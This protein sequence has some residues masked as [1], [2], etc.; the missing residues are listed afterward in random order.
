MST[1]ED[2]AIMNQKR[3]IDHVAQKEG[4]I[5]SGYVDFSTKIELECYNGHRWMVTPNHVTNGNS[6]CPKCPRKVSI[7]SKENFLRVVA[8]RKGII[9][10]NYINNNTHIALRCHLGHE[11]MATP[12][13]IAGVM[14]SWCPA[15]SGNCPKE[16]ANEFY[17]IVSE[18]GGIALGEYIDT[19]TKVVIKCSNNHEWSCS[20]HSIISC[21]TW[22]IKCSNLCPEQAKDKFILTVTNKGGIILGQ[23]VNSYT[24]VRIR[25]RYDH[26]WDCVPGNI[27]AGDWCAGCAG[28][29]PEANKRLIAIVTERKGVI[30]GKYINSTSKIPFQCQ[31]G[32]I[33]NTAPNNIVNSKSWCPICNESHGE[34]AVRLI[35]EKYNIKFEPQYGH[36]SQPGRRYDFYFV[37]NDVKFYLEYDGEQHFRHVELFCKTTE[38]YES[39]RNVDIIKTHAVINSDANII[40]L[41]YTL[42]NEELESHILAAINRNDKLYI[43]NPKMYEWIISGINPAPIPI[44]LN[45]RMPATAIMPPIH[46][47]LNIIK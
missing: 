45:I 16:A 28:I 22:C 42:T 2:K 18:R 20:P 33:W 35:L 37:Y 5:L 46:M 3:F 7:Q 14:N 24:R 1:R 8:E 44:T 11:W 34:R 41:D 17:R 29:S 38:D 15:C 30:L 4:K 25:C 36:P 10:G 31:Q 47:T 39:R 6:W 27:N 40:R 43:S 26:E 32:H 21:G 23:Y 13:S 12:H 19:N 9:I